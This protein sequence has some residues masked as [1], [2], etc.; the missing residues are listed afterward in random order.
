ME[1]T[2][3][4]SG[5]SPRFSRWLRG[6][7]AQGDCIH[8]SAS[9]VRI[10][11]GF[12]LERKPGDH[13]VRSAL[14]VHAD[15]ARTL[16]V[17]AELRCPA[18]PQQVDAELRPRRPR[19][20]RRRA[21]AP[22]RPPA[23]RRRATAPRR[24]PASQT[25]GYGAPQA[26]SKQT[27]SYGAPQAP[28]K[29]DA[30]LRRPAGPGQVGPAGLSGA[31]G[32]VSLDPAPRSFLRPGILVVPEHRHRRRAP[33]SRFHRGSSGSISLS[34]AS[35]VSRLHP[36]AP[37]SAHR[38]ERAALRRPARFRCPPRRGGGCP[39]RVEL[40]SGKLSLSIRRCPGS[41][42]L[43]D[44]RSGA[45]RSGRCFQG[46]RAVSQARSGNLADCSGGS[47]RARKAA[48]SEA[49]DDC[50]G[51]EAHDDDLCWEPGLCGDLG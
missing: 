20:S 16:E 6:F 35:R 7:L 10:C 40:I 14:Q 17:D 50:R 22:R 19:A 42:Y 21:T 32:G 36:L 34:S 44:E 18:G 29:S 4:W 47:P 8:V 41:S 15:G 1:R 11:R 5:A 28:S 51:A 26:P 48:L 43:R 3:L 38:G 25:P 46:R 37:S 33:A 9:R 49:F 13:V 23:S 2:R 45:G 24:P 27:P 31:A 12:G 39:W 30:G